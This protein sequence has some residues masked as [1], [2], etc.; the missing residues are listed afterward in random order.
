M[1]AQAEPAGRLTTQSY[2]GVHAKQAL[3]VLVHSRVEGHKQ[4]LVEDHGTVA[5]RHAYLRIGGPPVHQLGGCHVRGRQGDLGVEVDPG[6]Q[7]GHK[8]SRYEG[9]GE[10]VQLARGWRLGR[11]WGG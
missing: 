3:G 7:A 4:A 10:A 6:P 2:R 11:G 5:I 9:L 1:L 8:G